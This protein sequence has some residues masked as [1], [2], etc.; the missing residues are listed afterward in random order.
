[1][2]TLCMHLPHTHRTVWSHYYK[3]QTVG[4]LAVLLN[5]TTQ[6]PWLAK[7]DSAI[8]IYRETE[9]FFS[10]FWDNRNDQTRCV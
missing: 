10:Q 1:M 2:Y 9:A 3:S 5:T 6:S 8:S 4:Q 7:N